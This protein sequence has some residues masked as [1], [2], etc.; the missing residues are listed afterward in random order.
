MD[1]PIRGYRFDDFR[2]ETTKRR[3][4]G[5]RGDAIPL[6]GRAYDVLVQLV[7]HRDRVV[8][9][10]E[11]LQWVWPQTIVEDNN[12]NQA[13]TAVRRALGDTRGAPRFIVTIAGR[14]YQFVCD[15]SPLVEQPVESPTLAP[16]PPPGREIDSVAVTAGEADANVPGRLEDTRKNASVPRRA[17]LATI[18]VAAAATGATLWWNRAKQ[19]PG[20]P[21]SIAIL[22]FKPLLADARNPAME[23]GVT[24]LLTNRLGRLPGIVVLPLSSVMRFAAL[25]SDPL[26]AGRQLHVDAVVDG[27]VYMQDDRVRI[28][29][30]LLA[31]EG[32]S[33]W[34]NAYTQPAGELLAVQDSLA[35][36]LAS[37]LTSEL[38]D[39]TRSGVVAHETSDVEAWQLYANGRYQIERRD[40]ASLRR[41]AGFFDSALARDPR[42]A[43][44]SAGLSDAHTLTAVFGI[45][46]PVQAFAQA[47]R[48]ALRAMELDP[49][50]PPAHVA[51]GHVVTQYDL[52]LPGG[53]RHYQQALRLQ[54]EFARAMGQMALNLI[55]AGDL[56]GANDAIREARALEPASLAFIALSGWVTYF[57]RAYGDAERQLSQ[58]VEAAPD[59]ALPR[60]FLARVLLA[61]HEGVRVVRLLE[62]R[63]DPAPPTFSNLARA[64]AQI[65][66]ANSAKAEVARVEALASQ[67]YGVGFDLALIHLELGDRPRALDALERGMSDHSQMQGYLNVEPA[68]DPLHGEGRFRALVRRLALA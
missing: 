40:A 49:R 9:K 38:S 27:R 35:T 31:V 16:S 58:L 52:D 48:A 24:E 17:V 32:S 23:L 41:A 46:P 21:R 42:F 62:G 45:E 59:A 51:L 50:L 22:P 1:L 2:L 36:E 66:D 56:T 54:P 19:A 10:E 5:P 18:A 33:L 15:V 30:R 39:E 25:D 44:A 4:V 43:L 53:R 20:R 55:Q 14:G 28:T 13:I 65:G 6:S 47:R 3:L 61:K 64:Y 7:E 8:G 11:L 57:T 26:D 12:L 29:A 34:A 68:L 63:N 60:Q 67:G 37:A